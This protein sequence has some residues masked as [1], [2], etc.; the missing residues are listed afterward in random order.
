MTVLRWVLFFAGSGREVGAKVELTR[1]RWATLRFFFHFLAM[2]VLKIGSRSGGDS[3]WGGFCL[4]LV[5]V[6]KVV[7][8]AALWWFYEG[9][10]GKRSAWCGGVSPGWKESLV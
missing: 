5:Y 9:V 6:L 3:S 7:G 8:R 10:F 1:H 4:G 2:K